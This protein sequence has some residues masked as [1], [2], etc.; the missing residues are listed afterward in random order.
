MAIKGLMD[1][2]GERPQQHGGDPQS[3]SQMK[4]SPIGGPKD[5]VP[6]I[7]EF[8]GESE[9]EILM[10][11]DD[12]D[13]EDISAFIEADE[14]SDEEYDP[15]DDQGANEDEGG[16]EEE[17]EDDPELKQDLMKKKLI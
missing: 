12:L 14:G 10:F 9:D 3:M 15:R 2:Y 6:G 8:A 11:P 17:Q 7:D 16:E 13:E 1:K 5:A 4:T